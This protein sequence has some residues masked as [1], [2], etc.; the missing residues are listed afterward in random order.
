[1][2]ILKTNKHKDLKKDLQIISV[3]ASEVTNVNF[4]STY[5]IELVSFPMKKRTK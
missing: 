3:D 1:M 4:Q 2:N 5:S